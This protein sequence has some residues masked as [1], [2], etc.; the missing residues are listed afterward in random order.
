[1]QIGIATDLRNLGVSCNKIVRAGPSA[2][3]ALTAI[4]EELADKAATLETT[5]KVAKEQR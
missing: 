3:D 4:S 5:F 1:M 2:R